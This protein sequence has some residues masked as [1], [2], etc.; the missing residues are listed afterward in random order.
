VRFLGTEDAVARL[1]VLGARE[2]ALLQRA[3]DHLLRPFPDL[4]RRVLDPAGLR[5]DLLVFL[6]I[7]RH[8][9]ARMVE[10]HAP[11]AGRALIDR[12]DVLRHGLGPPS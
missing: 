12:C 11:G 4:D 10:H 6:L 3:G 5:E 8:D 9:L 2:I 1:A 7:D